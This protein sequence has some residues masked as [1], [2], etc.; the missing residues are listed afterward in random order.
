[1]RHSRSVLCRFTVRFI[2]VASVVTGACATD[3]PSKAP[4]GFCKQSSEIE[5]GLVL[6]GPSYQ[7]KS[8][9]QPA[10]TYSRVPWVGH[11]VA[12]L[13]ERRDLDHHTMARILTGIDRA[14][15]YYFQLTGRAPSPASIYQHLLAITEVPTS[16]C[17]GAACG[18]PGSTGVELAGSTFDTLYQQVCAS[19]LFDQVVFYELGRNFWFYESQ[20]GIV[21]RSKEPSPEGVFSKGFAIENR[22]RSMEA[23]GVRGAPYNER[24]NFEE[25][26]YSILETLLDSYLKDS[27][28]NW[29]NTLNEPAAPKNDYG[30]GG[31]DFAAAILN[32][33]QRDGGETGMGRFWRKMESLPEA[34]EPIKGME[35]FLQ[36]AYSATGMDY[37]CVLRGDHEFTGPPRADLRQ[38]KVC[39][40]G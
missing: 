20:L 37:R 6:A 31:P 21:G 1:M 15:E 5:S 16:S 39:R 18:N 17:G 27:S 40:G 26:R 25:F 32:M 3:L 28:L 13:T 36:A 33:I 19:N 38:P 14:Y 2:L 8:F 34:N 22:F 35:N 30:W 11:H 24:M 29:E 9:D 12:L 7:Y 10:I 4:N 23:A